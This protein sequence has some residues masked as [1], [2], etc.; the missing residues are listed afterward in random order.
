[1]IG[2]GIASYLDLKTT[3]VPDKFFYILIGIISP[4]LILKYFQDFTFFKNSL[5]FGGLFSLLGLIF[6][7]TGQWGGADSFFLALIGFFFPSLSFSKTSIFPFPLSFLINLMF[8]GAVYMLIYSFFLTF[9]NKKFW[10]KFR[11][12]IEKNLKLWIVFS[13][14][15]FFL[16][17]F[18]FFQIFPVV[19]T[20]HFAFFI[21]FLFFS[22]LF[23]LKYAKLV[24]NLIF[25]RKIPVSKLKVGDMLAEIRELRGLTEVEVKQIKRTRKYVWIKEGIR[26]LPAFPLTFLFTVFFG[27]FF[28][29]LLFP[30]F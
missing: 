7:K 17:F 28:S 13:V 1:M 18:I 23:L 12:E 4:F 29:L 26:F 5:L 8:I 14:S 24:E 25:K 2:L 19:Q 16:T 15:L 11:F 20:F 27:E 30:I 6:Y 9:K 10:K 3:E 21:T 22:L